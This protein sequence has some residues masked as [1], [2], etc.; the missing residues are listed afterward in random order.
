MDAL[1][2]QVW[3]CVPGSMYIWEAKGYATNRRF[4]NKGSFLTY[5]TCPSCLPPMSLSWDQD[6]DADCGP[7]QVLQRSEQREMKE[8]G[9]H[10]NLLLS[11]AC[12]GA[13][14]SFTGQS[15]TPSLISS[16]SRGMN[17]D[18]CSNLSQGIIQGLVIL[19]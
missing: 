7:S 19:K 13:H 15:K 17:N 4:E 12:S 18:D 11:E 5:K 16:T 9:A 2:Q 6:T 3:L 14:T 8:E 1:S 10:S